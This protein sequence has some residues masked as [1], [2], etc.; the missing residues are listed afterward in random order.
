M[1]FLKQQSQLIE[2]AITTSNLEELKKLLHQI[3]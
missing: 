2:N 1:F 3:M